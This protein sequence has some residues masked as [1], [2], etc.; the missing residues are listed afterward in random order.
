MSVGQHAFNGT[1]SHRFRNL[2]LNY[3]VRL[4]PFQDLFLALCLSATPGEESVVLKLRVVLCQMP[5]LVFAFG[6]PSEYD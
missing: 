2:V 6:I 4:S 3:E 5:E 1:A